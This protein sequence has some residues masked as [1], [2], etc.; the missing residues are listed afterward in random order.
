MSLYVGASLARALSSARGAT[1]V[2]RSATRR[3]RSVAR[4]AVA[5][6]RVVARVADAPRGVARVVARVMRASC[7]PCVERARVCGV[8]PS[9]SLRA[10]GRATPHVGASRAMARVAR[11]ATTAS[12]SLYRNALLVVKTTPMTEYTSLIGSGELY[13]TPRYERVKTR[14]ETHKSGV[15]AVKRMLEQRG[16]AFECVERHALT[17][18]SVRGHDL[19]VA[20]GGDGTTLIS[21]HHVRDAKVPILGINTDPATKDELAKMYLTNA[22]VDERRSTGHLCAANRFDAETVLDGALRGTLKPTRLARIRTVLNGKVLEPALNDVLI[23]HPSP[24]AVSRYSV[25]LPPTAR[26]GDG[27]DESAKRFFH[28]RSSGVRTCTASGSTAAMYSAG[29]EI[30]PHDSMSMQYMDREPIYYDHAPPPSVGHGYYERGDALSFR[31]NSRVGTIYIDGAHVKHDVVLGDDVEM[32]TDAPELSLFVS[33]WF[34]EA[35]RV[36]TGLDRV[37]KTR[38]NWGRRK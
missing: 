10:I 28:V 32:S 1:R 5:P 14:H 17:E 38:E 34:V 8:E 25:R 36:R 4:R 22:C 16:V 33:K 20:L 23:A 31:W 27:Y 18:E 26:G 11:A 9:R 29:G 19:I 13:D 3:G 6:R 37:F 2:D 21:A 15:K 7:A 30:M 24:A 35:R 12:S